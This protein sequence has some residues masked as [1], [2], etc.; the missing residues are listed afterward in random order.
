MKEFVAWGA[1]RFKAFADAVVAI[2]MTLLILPLMEAV[3]DA[4]R[5]QEADASYGTADFL[6]EHQ[7]QIVSFALSFVLIAVS[8]LSHH[9]LYDQVERITAPLLWIN[10]AWMFTIVCLPVTTALLG[11][12]EADPLQAALYIGNLTLTQVT[13]LVARVYLLRHDGL[14]AAPRDS[15]RRG[16]IADA[17]TAVLFLVAMVIA[18]IIPGQGYFALF[19]L[20]LTPLVTSLMSRTLPGNRPKTR[21]KGADSGE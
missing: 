10:I 19:L 7:G 16:A 18:M 8:W 20:M 12:M 13:S 1:E 6:T 11:A 15:I 2:A 17:A 5:M 14:S 9:R 4:A 3:T 21:M